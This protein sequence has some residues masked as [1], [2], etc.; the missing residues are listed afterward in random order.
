M[1][2][3]LRKVDTCLSFRPVVRGVE[4]TLVLYNYQGISMSLY[5]SLMEKMNGHEYSNYFTALC[6]FHSDHSPSLFVYDDG[7]FRCAACGKKGNNK[8]LERKV[9][10]GFVGYK[11]DTVSRVLPQWRKW[12]EQWGDLE[13]IADHA[14][15]SLKRFPQF[16]AYYKKRK[17]ENFIEQG[18]LGYIGGWAVIPV[19]DQN[20]RVVDIVCRAVKGKGDTRYVVKPS[21]IALRPLYVPNRAIV[22]ESDKVFVVFGI[23]DAIS[24]VL[25]GLPV[26]TGITGKS[27][28]AEQLILLKKKLVIIPD[29]DE[30]VDAHNLANKLGWRARVKELTFPEGTKDPD[31]IRVMYG[32]K[33]LKEILT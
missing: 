27:L 11:N 33:Y 12:E 22:E 18:F 3:P 26:V 1:S 4:G 5:E 31:G 15:Q 17:C 28:S 21:E 20:H 30:E 29:A 13:G 24:L 7:A 19:F 25:I 14:H 10:H 23:F 6:P 16:Q 2:K 8:F 9:S 32:D